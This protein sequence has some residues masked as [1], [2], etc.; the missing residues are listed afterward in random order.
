MPHT[1]HDHGM[2]MSS[3][4]YT[5]CICYVFDPGVSL[6]GGTFDIPDRMFHSL[7]HTFE[8]AL[9]HLSDVRELTPE[10]FY[11]VCVTDVMV[12]VRV[13]VGIM[14]LCFLPRR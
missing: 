10:F 9:T 7:E 3:S 12:C 6:Q 4:S 2:R 1:L 13:R 8:T 11:M 14:S 5:L